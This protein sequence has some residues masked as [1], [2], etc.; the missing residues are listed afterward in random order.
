MSKIESFVLTA[1]C[2]TIPLVAFL[3]AATMGD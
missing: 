3:L 1:L 2:Y